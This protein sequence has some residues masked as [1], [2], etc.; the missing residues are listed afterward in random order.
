MRTGCRLPREILWRVNQKGCEGQKLKRL[1]EV[2]DNEKQLQ[3]L[4]QMADNAQKHYYSK[5]KL[6]V[7]R[8]FNIAQTKEFVNN[9]LPANL[10]EGRYQLKKNYYATTPKNKCI[11]NKIYDP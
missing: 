1:E 5:Q 6:C 4:K 3:I 11:V 2:P 7:S 9:N 8:E 10:S